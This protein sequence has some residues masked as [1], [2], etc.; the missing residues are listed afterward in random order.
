MVW[1]NARPRNVGEAI[2]HEENLLGKSVNRENKGA[3]TYGKKARFKAN[4][5]SFQARKPSRKFR[6]YTRNSVK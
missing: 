2:A 4:E 5:R 3:L 1:R 6:G